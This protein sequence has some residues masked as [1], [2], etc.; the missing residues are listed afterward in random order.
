MNGILKRL[1]RLGDDELHSLSEAIDMELERRTD[2]ENVIPDSARR[3]AVQ[4]SQS[5]R[6]ETGTS[7][8]PVRVTGLRANRRKRRAA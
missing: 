6:R 1:K 4:R 8:P 5:Y 2:I 7:A 3:R